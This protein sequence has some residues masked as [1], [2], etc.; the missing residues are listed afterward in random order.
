MRKGLIVLLAA[1]L[2]VA[3][4]LPA[5]A[6]HSMTGFVRVK[7]RMQ[8]NYNGTGGSGLFILP[9]KDA[10]TAAYVEQRQRFIFDW[11]MENA[12]ARAYFEID[13]GA[14]GDSAY[15]VGRN[16]G[17]ALEGDSVNLETKNFYIWFNVP[18]TSMRFQVGLQNQSD[19][20]DGVIFGVAD[21]AG[22]FLTGK[23]EPVSYRLGWA[24]W[25]ENTTTL[26]NDVDL[27]VAEGTFSPTKEAKL[28]INLYMIRDASGEGSPV[29]GNTNP[30]T[31]FG[32][33]GAN[34]GFA[35]TFEYHPSAFYY[36]GLDGSVKAGP[37]GISGWAFYNGGKFE[38]ASFDGGVTTEDVKVK[39]WAA[40]LRGDMDLGPGKFFLAGAYVSGHG[41]NDTDFKSIVT[42]GDYA[43]AGAFPFYKWDLQ[44]LFPNGDDINGSA[45]LAYNANNQGRGVMAFAAG[46]KQKFSD[47]L[48]G[49]IG[50]G[51]LADAK[52]SI[53]SNVSGVSVNK[54]KAIEV[55]ANVNYALVKGID[56]GLYGAYAFLTDWEDYSGGVAQV[57]SA[58][59][60][61]D[62]ADD[63]FKIYARLNYGF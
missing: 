13:M 46:Y 58:G 7:A 41:E 24:K 23:M 57:N 55:N 35:E 6:E 59:T 49:K 50:L 62:E 51:Y 56:L 42:G 12:G 32:R 39:G 36:I 60:G 3:F 26:D 21:M 44:I 52:N 25:Q 17:A 63:I 2:V 45:A 37:A 22:I 1:V 11:N 20:Y 4:T 8:Q 19:S 18:N 14:W 5:M 30:T 47:M 54:H 43:L 9:E 61:F 16:Q 28:G 48:S 40:S 29:G 34:Y 15:T 53:G 31:T 27:Y 10:P 38:K 33:L